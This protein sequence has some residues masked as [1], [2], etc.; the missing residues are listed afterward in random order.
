MPL[1]L[2][3]RTDHSV[4]PV[5]SEAPN[6]TTNSYQPKEPESLEGSDSGLPAVTVPKTTAPKLSSDNT[7]V[8]SK[9][10][11]GSLTQATSPGGASVVP[12]HQNIN[13]D[14]QGTE[15][16]SSSPAKLSALQKAKHEHQK[17][18][19]DKLEKHLITHNKDKFQEYLITKGLN[20]QPKGKQV[21]CNFVFQCTQTWM[22]SMKITSSYVRPALNKTNVCS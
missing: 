6:D 12:D 21:I 14:Q 19:A 13:L 3:I 7:G 15:E 11:P 2:H 4:P 9:L 16:I 8:Q 5:E 22:F 20:Y 10:N 18:Q 1:S 17:A